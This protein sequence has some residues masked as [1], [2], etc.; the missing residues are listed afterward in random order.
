MQTIKR[1]SE[2]E[3]VYFDTYGDDEPCGYE[4]SFLVDEVYDNE[5]EYRDI[6]EELESDECPAKKIH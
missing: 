4:C 5:M 1:K 3:A 6:M 2:V